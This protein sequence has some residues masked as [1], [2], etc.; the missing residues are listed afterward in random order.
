MMEKEG[1][2]TERREE[3]G[4]NQ[5]EKKLRQSKGF[6]KEHVRMSTRKDF[7]Q[8]VVSLRTWKSHVVTVDREKGIE[9]N[10]TLLILTDQR[11]TVPYKVGTKMTSIEVDRTLSLF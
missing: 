5:I 6:E 9:P 10:R 7:I 3:N 1:K 11:R 2:R 8:I 4:Q